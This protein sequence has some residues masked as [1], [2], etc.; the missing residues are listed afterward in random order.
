MQSF[1][2]RLKRMPNDTQNIIGQ[3]LKEA[4]ILVKV[5]KDQT[6]H[7]VECSLPINYKIEE[8]K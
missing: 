6:I 2:D 7:S 5:N 8:V 1:E 3:M 4:T